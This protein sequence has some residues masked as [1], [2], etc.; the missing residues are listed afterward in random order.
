MRL[1][2]A[3][4]PLRRILK[5]TQRALFA[6]GILLLSYCAFAL[7][8]AW[9]FQRRESRNLDRLL[10]DRRAASAATLL[11]ESSTFPGGAPA[12]APDGLIGRIEI[13]RLLL[14]A[15]V[16]E[17]I[18]KTTLRRAVGHIPGTALPGQP[19]NVGLAGHRD[20]FFRPLK[21]LKIKDEVQVS[22][23]NGNFKYEV[24]SLRVVDPDD[25]GV[26]APSGENVLTMVTCYPFYYVGPAPKR[27][28]VRARQVS[29]QALARLTVK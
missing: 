5:W 17:G 26:L 25:V 8:D 1:V 22:T 3:K 23:L 6:C 11:A 18:D 10:R 14:S 19:G 9:V 13:P 29:P 16:V 2:I 27:F 24:E 15:V 28:I 20:T 4:K 12:V 21:D 7:V